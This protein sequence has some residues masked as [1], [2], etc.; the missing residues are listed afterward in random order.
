[1]DWDDIKSADRIQLIEYCAVRHC[2]DKAMEGILRFGYDKISD[3]RLLQ[4]SSATL[5]K[6][7]TV[8]I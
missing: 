3:K 5:R 4:I 6:T 1:M 2:Y 7:Q 8:R